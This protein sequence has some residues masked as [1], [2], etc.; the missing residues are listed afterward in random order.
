MLNF[1]KGEQKL[2]VIDK[3]LGK[4][5]F[6]TN[7]QSVSFTVKI[8]VP[9][10][11]VYDDNYACNFIIPRHVSRKLKNENFFSYCME[12]RKIRAER[13]AVADNTHC[14]FYTKGSTFTISFFVDNAFAQKIYRTAARS[15]FFSSLYSSRLCNLIITWL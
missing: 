12:K 8:S 3:I 6:C 5:V 4:L 7:F 9:F 10:F 13:I 14:Y 11:P 15:N 2:I 1:S